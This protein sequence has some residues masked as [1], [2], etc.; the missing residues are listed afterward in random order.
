M[1]DIP[2]AVY[3]TDDQ[4]LEAWDALY[5]GGDFRAEKRGVADAATKQVCEYW[6]ARVRELGG[7]IQLGLDSRDEPMNRTLSL[8]SETN[9]TACERHEAVLQRAMNFGFDPDVPD[10]YDLETWLD[11]QFKLQGEAALAAFRAPGE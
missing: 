1:T 10:E 5:P 6:E 4:I 11:H 2:E 7:V 8:I 9:A 3:L